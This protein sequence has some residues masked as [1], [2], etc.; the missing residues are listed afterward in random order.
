MRYILQIILCLWA[1]SALAF[2]PG[3]IGA[4]TRGAAGAP[5]YLL[6]EDFEDALSGWTVGGTIDPDDTSSPL[7]GFQSMTIPFQATVNYAEPP[8]WTSA[9]TVYFRFKVNFS[10]LDNTEDVPFFAL[11][12]GTTIQF[13]L[14]VN[15]A[16]DIEPLH[17]SIGSTLSSTN[18]VTGTTYRIWG[19]YVADPGG[20][21]GTFAF[22][23]GTTDIYSE[24][25]AYGA[26]ITA[27]NGG[28]T[29]SMRVYH[30]INLGGPFKIDD[31]TIS[32]T[33]LGDF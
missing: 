4:V 32:E 20:S 18:L 1:S 12:A 17:G 31:I 29:T 5:T 26:D 3:F 16:N 24:S 13:R 23:M 6:N 7:S 9:S 25:T 10:V 27:G 30:L 2:S 11:R 14:Y 19:V 8:T 21:T 22:R 15:A 28:A 33:S